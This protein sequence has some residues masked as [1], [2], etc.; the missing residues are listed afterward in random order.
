MPVAGFS[1][2]HRVL[3]PRLHCH[4]AGAFLGRA[5]ALLGQGHGLDQVTFSLDGYDADAMAESFF[6]NRSDS[7]VLE[8][9]VKIMGIKELEVEPLPQPNNSV[10]SWNSSRRRW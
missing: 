4:K 8:E 3:N 5:F 9:I 7:G 2:P 1:L 10:G 6:C